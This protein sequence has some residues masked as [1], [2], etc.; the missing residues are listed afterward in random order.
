MSDEAE[1]AK[2]ALT[3]AKEEYAQY[4]NRRRSPAP[5]YKSGDR[6]WLYSSDIKTTRPS[7][8][9]AHP[10]LGLYVIDRPVGLGAYK[11]KLPPS[12]R[13]TLSLEVD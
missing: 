6:V 4:Y 13:A 12:V 8:K 9:L 2:A 11:L 7:A 3:K 10:R 1:E 5:E